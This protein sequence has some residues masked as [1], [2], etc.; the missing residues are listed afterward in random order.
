MDLLLK[1][2]KEFIMNTVIKVF[3]RYIDIAPDKNP[4]DTSGKNLRFGDKI[5]VVGTK[6]SIL[7]T[8][9][10]GVSKSGD[11]LMYLSAYKSHIDSTHRHY[12]VKYDWPDK[13]DDNDDSIK[14]LHKINKQINEELGIDLYA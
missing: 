8:H 12:V 6:R 14:Q 9:Y 10:L 13:L 1:S 7:L 2:F 4:E 11:S 3:G 5:L